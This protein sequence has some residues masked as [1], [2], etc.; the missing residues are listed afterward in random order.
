MSAFTPIKDSLVYGYVSSAGRWDVEVIRAY[1]GEWDVYVRL[2]GGTVRV[3]ELP[4]DPQLRALLEP[5]Q[6]QHTYREAMTLARRV[7]RQLPS[8][9]S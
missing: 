3:C 1:V 8:A 9:P 2:D 6:N 7:L 4:L 5:Y